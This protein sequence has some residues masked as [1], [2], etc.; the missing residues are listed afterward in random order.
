MIYPTISE[1]IESIKY[2]E[3]NFATLTN[4]RSELDDDGHPIMSSGNF[5]VV[6]KMKDEQTGKFHAVKCFLKEQDGRAKAY[7]LISEELDKTKSTYIL[8]VKYLEKELF[9]NSNQSDEKEFPI[10]IMDWVE[11]QTLTSFLKDIEDLINENV[12]YWSDAEEYVAL[13]ELRCLPSNFIRMASWLI[14]QPFAHGDLKPDNIMITPNGAFVLV[15]YDGMYV[16]AMQGMVKQCAGTPNYRHPKERVFNKT[17][18]NYA[19]SVIALSLC[20]FALQPQRLFN[21]NDYC[22]ISEEESIKLHELSLLQDSILMSDDLFKELLAIYLHVISQNELNSELFNKSLKEFLVPKSYDI[23][24]TEMTDFEQEHFWEDCFGVR[25]SLDGRKVLKASKD[26]NGVDYIIR[27]GVLVICES[28]FQRKGLQSI[29]LPDSVISIGKL[30]FANNDNMKYCNIPKSV[31]FID[32]NNPWGGCFNISKMD[33]MS[34]HFVIQDGVLYSS[35]YLIVYGFIYWHP[36]VSINIKTRKISSNAFWSGRQEYNT[37]IKSVE[38]PNVSEI[39]SAAFYNCKAAIFIF[40]CNITEIGKEAFY[41]CE[42]LENINLS[43]VTSIP[44]SAFYGCKKLKEITFS[45]DLDML[46]EYAFSNC[47]SLEYTHIPKSVKYISDDVFSG[48]KSLY[49]ITVDN[50]NK[51]YSSIDGILFNK[52]VTKLIKF[53][54]A[55]FVREYI[56]PS[57]V[58]VI[59]N[60]AFSDCVSIESIICSNKVLSFGDSVFKNCTNLKNCLIDLDESADS[61]SFWRL[62][63]FLF[64]FKNVDKETKIKGYKF[65]ERSASL[66]NSSAQFYLAKCFRFG[67]YG[68]IDYNE[69]INWLERSASNHNLAAMSLLGLEYTIGRCTSKNYPKAYSLLSELEEIGI[70]AELVCNGN[71]NAPLGLLYEKGYFVN[72]DVDKAIEYYRR[73]A[74]WNDPIAEYCIGRCYENGIGLKVDLHKAKEYYIKAK[75]HKSSGASKALDR[76]ER[77]IA[78]Q[79]EIPF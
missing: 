43:S 30:A 44:K 73:G 46:K 68:T 75:E 29:T 77:L 17:L 6:F 79:D 19:I 60:E 59:A 10:L 31:K 23:L 15:D 49:E 48:C 55:K 40:S 18:D 47:V 50:N 27:D 45:S 36:N 66:N 71:F 56:V 42:S 54:P 9:V 33:C 4:L 67:W 3:D 51:E 70:F 16:P 5:A 65:I 53:P 52:N 63:Y 41:S 69:Y 7:K 58:F 25:Y 39:C 34:P 11:G 21:S 2:A 8:P 64:T 28:S 1:Y 76:V 78:A 38:L 26:L 32:D 24:D 62:G 22:L 57:S 13:F 14:K 72:K 35:N 20:G 61:H 74:N 37:F 12:S